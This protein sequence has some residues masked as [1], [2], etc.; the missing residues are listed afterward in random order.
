MLTPR[1]HSQHPIVYIEAA[2]SDAHGGRFHLSRTSRNVERAVRALDGY[3][4]PVINVS[5]D[6]ETRSVAKQGNTL[7]RMADQAERSSGKADKDQ[8]G[9]SSSLFWAISNIDEAL[10]GGLSPANREDLLTARTYLQQDQDIA[11]NRQ[12]LQVAVQSLG[13]DATPHLQAVQG[14]SPG[15]DVSAHAEPLNGYFETSLAGLETIDVTTDLQEV[16][17]AITLLQEVRN[18]LEP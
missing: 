13:P 2:L 3:V 4:G 14:D 15:Q 6:S 9:A 11:K 12:T 16:G 8:K 5:N 7:S 1:L 17:Q 18:R 10:Q